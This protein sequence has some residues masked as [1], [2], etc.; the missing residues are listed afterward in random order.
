MLCR[1]FASNKVGGE[2]RKLGWNTRGILPWLGR[3]WGRRG[4][5]VEVTL[6]GANSEDVGYFRVGVTTCCHVGYFFRRRAAVLKVVSLAT[7]QIVRT[8]CRS[9]AVCGAASLLHSYS[10]G[11]RRT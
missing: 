7:V 8:V 10:Y 11:R 3:S 2:G 5:R 6:L 1:M 9:C 4:C